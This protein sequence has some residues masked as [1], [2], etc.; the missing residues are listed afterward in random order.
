M[1]RASN[2][3][4]DAL[5]NRALDGEEIAPTAP[6]PERVTAGGTDY[7]SYLFIDDLLE[8]QRP[9]TPG[10]HDELLFIV[11]H[12]AYELWF[13][14]ILHE[15]T[16][17]RDELQA[18]RPHVA[19]PRL[20]R[21]VAV[22]RLL[23]DQLDVLETM[24]PEGFLEFRDPLAPA[25]GFQSRQFREIEWLSGVR[26]TWPGG[27]EPPAGPSLYEAF[28]AGLGL[29]EDSGERLAALADLYRD[30]TA[31]PLR[32]AWHRGRRAA[33]RPRRG[34]RPLAPPPR[35]D[36]RPAR[37]GR[38]PARAARRA[39]RTCA[40]RSIAA[41]STSSGPSGS[42]SDTHAGRPSADELR[43]DGLGSP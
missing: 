15:L 39:S 34:G 23:L 38:A 21:V 28:R 35:A 25:S 16:A 37:S 31:D 40:R 9:L 27:G 26:D 19:A 18:G 4:A 12:Q 24:S 17:A 41:S 29:P 36:G 6:L 20:R 1:P 43:G 42:S 22:E 3:A 14:L 13:K 10:A 2:A 30:H 5:V 7:A 32:A 33:A 8:L 11:V